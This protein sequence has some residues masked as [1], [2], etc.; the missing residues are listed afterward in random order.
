MYL[1][2]SGLVALASVNSN[3]LKPPSAVVRTRKTVPVARRLRVTETNRDR[4]VAL[5]QAGH[6]VA[7]VAVEVGVA[8][9]TVTRTLRRRSV[10]VRPWGVRS[11]KSSS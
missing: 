6:D 1:V 3:T 8:R 9:S 10:Q 11:R 7:E 5:Y 4:I 2:Y